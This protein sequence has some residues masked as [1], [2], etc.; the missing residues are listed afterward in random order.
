MAKYLGK[1]V[2]LSVD[3]DDAG[4]GTY[5]TIAQ[6]MDINGPNSDGDDVDTTTRDNADMYRSFLAGWKNPGELTFDIVFD[7][8]AT[9]HAS[10]MS[11]H[12]ART[13]VPWKLTWP[14]GTSKMATFRGYVK[15]LSVA[16]PL[17]D[18][19]SMSVT[20]KIAGA[21]TWAAAAA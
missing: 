1:E 5:A 14:S 19:L 20:V 12:V 9:T 13:E 2:T 6:V 3:A 4:A 8:A 10:L 11:L 18:K 16:S 7:A 17:E 21:I 15:T